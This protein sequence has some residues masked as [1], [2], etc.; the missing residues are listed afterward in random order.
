MQTVK[1]RLL[2]AQRKADLLFK[3]VDRLDMIAPGK[4]EK[5]INTAVYDLAFGLFGIKK[6][7]HK[8]IVRAGKNTLHP[9]HQNP[10]NLVVQ[11]NDI[12]FL[13]FGPVFED[14]EADFG[15]TFVVGDD[16]AMKKVQQDIGLAFYEGKNYF[17]TQQDITAA[18]LYAFM[19]SMAVKYGWELGGRHCGHLIGK[20]PHER[21][22]DHEICSYI[23]PENH[24]RLREPDVYG[25]ACHWILEVHFIDRKKEIGGFTEELLTL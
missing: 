25:K 1:D 9:Y 8:R 6:Y 11:T 4:T 24:R 2:D 20:F 15:R 18:E 16:P 21:V 5:E 13:D 14:W 7:W 23:H 17:K 10:P 12:V 22:E 3:E 19:Q